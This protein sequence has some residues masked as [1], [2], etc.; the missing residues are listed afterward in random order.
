MIALMQSVS[1]EKGVG[2]SCVFSIALSF[3][4]TAWK[5]SGSALGLQWLSVFFSENRQND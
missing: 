2:V 1:V 4:E 3:K 5:F